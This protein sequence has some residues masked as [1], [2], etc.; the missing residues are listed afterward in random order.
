[1]RDWINDRF[2]RGRMVTREAVV[3]TPLRLELRSGNGHVRVRGIEGTTARVRAEIDLKGFQRDDGGPAEA[4]VAA[5]IVFEGDSLRI[6]S[7]ASARDSLSVH[8]EV[9]VPFA[10]LATLTVM[11]GA[12]ELRGIEGPLA[13]T[14]ANGPLEIEEIGGAIEVQ[15]NNGP[16]RIHRCRGIVEARVSNGPIHIED[17]TGPVDVQVHNGP[18]S[19]E[20][21]DAGVNASAT[22]GPFVYRGAV[23]GDFDVHS[24]R[25][26]IVLELPSDSRFEL[27]A[28]V[29]RGEVYSDFDVNEAAGALRGERVPRVVLRADRGK[30]V[31]QQRSETMASR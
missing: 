22:N 13:V 8:Y 29:E 7:P 12:V 6:E 11:N 14:L 10:T 2:G 19:I 31:V 16:A 24:T 25:G 21:V 20:N 1:M 3:Q 15:L 28:E 26:S 17:V 23:G 18:I 9:S 4:M 27:D 30:I 5:G